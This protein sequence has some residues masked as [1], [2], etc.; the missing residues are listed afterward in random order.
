MFSSELLSQM[1]QDAKQQRQHLVRIA[2]LI[3]Q[4]E[5]QKAKEALAAFSHEFAHD[6]R[7]HFHA[8]LFYEHLQAWADAFREIALAIFLEP[9]DHVRG[10][11]YPLAAR[12]LAKMGI[13]APIDAVLERGW[14]MCKTLYRPSE[15]ELR[16]QEYFQ[17]GNR[18]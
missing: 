3:Q 9:D 4:G 1:I 10:I 6:V 5:T 18:D 14:Q 16:K 15:R 7:A 17:Q 12:Y 13:T 11:Y 2:Q 8:A